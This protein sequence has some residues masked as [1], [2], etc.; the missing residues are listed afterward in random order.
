MTK[1]YSF[2]LYNIRYGAGRGWRFNLPLPLSGYL[3]NTTR[4]ISHITK[5]I[6]SVDPDI[7]GL[8]E[9]DRGSFRTNKQNQAQDIAKALGY[10]PSFNSKY[11]GS[12]LAHKIPIMN[13][14]GNAVLTRPDIK[15]KRI[16]YFK[17]GVK[18]MAIELELEDFNIFLIHL[19]LTYRSRQWQL[20][21]LYKLIK[22][23]DKPV[24]VAG[25]F[26]IFWGE[27]EIELFMAATGLSSMNK[28]NVP[29]FPSKKP[30]RQLDFILHSP[31]I[32]VL[33]FKVLDGITFSDHLPVSCK[34]SVKDR[35]KHL[36]SDQKQEK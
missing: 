12:S 31:D 1:K 35:Q 29:S 19:S 15:N 4:N 5:F 8:I 16:H 23:V 26:N 24:I 30:K 6:K 11:G 36:E 7:V 10:H 9:V 28:D 25:D 17:K 14:Q 18:R 21:D 13:M 22:K 34:F 2:L 33:D 3:K 20:S 32:K 27:H